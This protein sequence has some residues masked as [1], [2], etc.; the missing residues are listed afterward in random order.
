[1]LYSRYK[2]NLEVVPLF[3][4]LEQLIWWQDYL[5]FKNVV[6]FLVGISWE[7][8]FLVRGSLTTFYIS[9]K[10]INLPSFFL[11]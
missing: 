3:N 1:M 10:V 11:Y 5:I 7:W 9:S 4:A 2:A 6:K 8:W